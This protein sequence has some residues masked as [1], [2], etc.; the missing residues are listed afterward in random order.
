[1]QYAAMNGK[2]VQLASAVVPVTDHG[3]L[4]GLGLF[5]TFRTYR[6]RP[7]LLERHL[8]RMASGCAELGIPFEVTASEVA[9]WISRLMQANQLEDAYVRYTVSAGEAPLGLPS[10][11]YTSPTHI[12]LAK[13]L[14]E[15]SPTLYESGKML[16][17]LSTPRNT[18]EGQVRLKSLHYMNSILAKRELNHLVQQDQRVQGSEGL[19][20]TREGFVAEGMVSNVF[21]V[22]ERVLYTPSLSTGILPGITR[23]VVME[24]AA[25]QGIACKETLSPWEELWQADEIFVTGSVAELVPV[26]TL[27][28]LNAQETTISSG[29]I[30][31]VTAVL[32]RMY[33]EK[34]GYTS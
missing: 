25:E 20:L 28:D 2:L 11:D 34:A 8:E 3:F 32:L 23:A 27:R 33:R 7:Y 18:P 30:G 4:Y 16:Q 24:I 22:R 9:D 19:Q 6:G 13:A 15:P 29:Q 14:P 17:R 10:G 26:T 12:V 31:P 21:W 5:E 1:M